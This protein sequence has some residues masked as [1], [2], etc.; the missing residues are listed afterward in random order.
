MV[1]LGSEVK[2]T[3]VF[4]CLLAAVEGLKIIMFD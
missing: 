4:C 3:H 2:F 1:V